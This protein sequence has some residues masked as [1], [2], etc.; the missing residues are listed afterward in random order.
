MTSRMPRITWIASSG[1]ENR[2]TDFFAVGAVPYRL[3]AVPMT[4]CRNSIV[5]APKLAMRIRS[6]RVASADA[7][8]GFGQR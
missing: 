6:S 3:Y 7:V 1:L 4:N 2:P 5:R 8:P